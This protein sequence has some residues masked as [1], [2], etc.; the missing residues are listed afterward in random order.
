[1]YLLAHLPFCS[2]AHLS[3]CSSADLF[4]RPSS[5]FADHG[6]LVVQRVLQ[7]WKGAHIPDI[8]QCHGDVSQV[9]PS[10]GALDRSP[11]EAL[12]KSLGCKSKFIGQGVR[13]AC[14]CKGRIALARESIPRADHLAD[15]ASEDPPP[16]FV[17]QFQRDIVFEFDGEVRDATRR[18]EGAIGE[19]A[20]G[21][22]GSDAARAR[23]AVIG[24]ERRVGFEREIEKNLGE[25]KIRALLRM[26]EAGVFADPAD[27]GALGEITLKDGTRVCIPAVP[28]RTPNLLLD[29]L[30]EFFHP[31]E[32][33]VVVISAARVGG[34]PALTP[35]PSPRGRGVRRGKDQDGFTFGENLTRVGAAGE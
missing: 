15:V 30:N 6:F 13:R 8:A 2:F 32:E 19:N 3:I 25:Q 24:D 21:G 10:P 9:A 14:I 26:D 29:K 31:R 12:V 18:V 27:T 20:T 1:M 4:D 23:A 35:S 7:N 16:N 33:D 22:A 11:L 28:Y 34:D 5:V 17:A